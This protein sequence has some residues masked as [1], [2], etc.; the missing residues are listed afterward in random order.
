MGKLVEH[1]KTNPEFKQCDLTKVNELPSLPCILSHYPEYKNFSDIKI[2]LGLSLNHELWSKEKVVD[3]CKKFLETHSKITQK[4]LLKENGLPTSKVIYNFFG[5]MQKFQEEIRSEVS[6]QSKYITKEEIVRA[7]KEIVYQNGSV[8][9]SRTEFFKLF[10][11]SQSVIIDRYGSFDSFVKAVNIT[12]SKT[13][14]AKYKKQEVDN[15]ILTYL[16]DGNSIPS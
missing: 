4:D 12:I 14:K 5:T 9:E 1:S 11:Y 7:T 3:A 2:A 8:F 10:P 6:K 13:K 16:K 15:L